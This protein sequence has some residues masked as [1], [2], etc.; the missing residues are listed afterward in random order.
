[1]LDVSRLRALQ[2]SSMQRYIARPAHVVSDCDILLHNQLNFNVFVK[3]CYAVMAYLAFHTFLTTYF[4]PS[5]QTFKDLYLMD[6]FLN[7][8]K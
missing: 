6:S 2:L 5:I 8:N 4:P 7:R 3:L 1:M